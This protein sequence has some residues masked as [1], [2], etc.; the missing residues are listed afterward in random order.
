MNMSKSKITLKKFMNNLQRSKEKEE[1]SGHRMVK[2]KWNSPDYDVNFASKKEA[3]E[4][5]K[6]LGE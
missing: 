1:F 2:I 6:S 5:Y 4:W 3:K